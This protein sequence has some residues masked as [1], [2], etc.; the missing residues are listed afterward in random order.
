MKAVKT[1]TDLAI[2]KE[3]V[4]RSM[5]DRI[6][7]LNGSA[8]HPAYIPF[9]IASERFAGLDF[10]GRK[11]EDWKYT[12]VKPFFDRRDVDSGSTAQAHFDDMPRAYPIH[13]ADGVLQGNKLD[14]P[15][16]CFAG[17]WKSACETPALKHATNYILERLRK[18]ELPI[19]EAM[20]LGLAPELTFIYLPKNVQLDKP[21]HLIYSNSITSQPESNIY[22]L[23]YAE[24][25]SEFR[26]IE[27]YA[28]NPG[29]GHFTNTSTRMYIDEGARVTH[30]RMQQESYE[31]NHIA[32][33]Y[34]AQQ[35]D[36]TYGLYVAE[37]GGKRVRHNIHVLHEGENITSNLY[38]AFIARDRQHIDTQ[39]FIDHALPHCQS[40]ELYKGILLDYGRGVFNGK[41]IVRPDAQKTNAFQQN[42][43]LVLSPHATIDS[44][45]QLEIFA[46]DV[47]C[48]HGATIGQ[49][50]TEALFYLKSRGLDDEAATAMLKKAFLKDVISQ[51]PDP[52]VVEYFE[53]LLDRELKQIGQDQK[54]GS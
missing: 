18:D 42:S 5:L 44:K 30:Y 19:F 15:D 53:Q 21:V 43:A 27:T 22:T 14:L 38:G 24:R 10:P 31:A 2:V 25:N 33:S 28:D 36:S 1:H 6:R 16:G 54:E 45:P 4:E 26:L 34:A 17:T 3:R 12:P 49:L 7:S 47:K 8:G 51:F 39:S 40:N 50:D 20:S 23:V 29:S 35:R 9:Q 32:H 11:D 13:I 52:E 41:I 46:D 48:S 37:F